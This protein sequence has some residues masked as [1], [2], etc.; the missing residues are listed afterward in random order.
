MAG[1]FRSPEDRGTLEELAASGAMMGP[2]EVSDPAVLRTVVR[3][4]T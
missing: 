2:A 1:R 3:T 4:A